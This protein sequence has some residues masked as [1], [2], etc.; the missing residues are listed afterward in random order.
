MV[1]V[2]IEGDIDSRSKTSNDNIEIRIKDSRKR[3][4][5]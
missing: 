4:C 1:G 5:G 3:R 2:N